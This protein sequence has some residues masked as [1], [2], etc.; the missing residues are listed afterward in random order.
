MKKL[1]FAALALALIVA[2][3]Q[4]DKDELTPDAQVI[5][6]DMSDF[7]LY[8]DYSQIAAKGA[9][10]LM[11]GAKHEY[12]CNYQM[13]QPDCNVRYNASDLLGVHF[14]FY[15]RVRFQN[16]PGKYNTDI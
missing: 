8:T 10:R 5:E 3:C 6:V 15:Y 4:S 9:V 16:F 13:D 12:R 2:A 11:K 14:H 7:Y 1:F